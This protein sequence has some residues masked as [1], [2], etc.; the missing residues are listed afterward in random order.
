MGVFLSSM[1]PVNCAHCAVSATSHFTEKPD[2]EFIQAI[3][4]MGQL[5]DLMAVAI[6]GGEPFFELDLLLSIVDLLKQAG[7]RVVVYTSGYWGRPGRKSKILSTLNSIDGLIMGV[8]LYHHARIPDENLIH[9]L[10]CA[11]ECGVWISAQVI[12]DGDDHDHM[13]YASSLFERAFGSQ[14]VEIVRII[15]IPL[16]AA[17]RAKEIKGFA[18]SHFLAGKMCLSIRDPILLRD[19]T[20]AACCNE[21][22]IQNKGPDIFRVANQ[23]LLERSIEKLQQRPPL[24]HLQKL[25]PSI[26][27]SLANL[28][29]GSGSSISGSSLCEACWEFCGLY[30]GLS[31]QLQ[32]KLDAMV[33][34]LAPFWSN[35]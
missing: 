35:N 16:V 11:A 33:N 15:P 19:G 5:P 6:T 26:L 30:M 7:K 21:E 34:V 14:W 25:P 23:G 4:Q 10:R 13:A 32:N 3:E 24:R 20:L 9:A 31:R 18:K 22:V 27:L 29:I 1:C 28:C 17:G 2:K 8:D 12:A